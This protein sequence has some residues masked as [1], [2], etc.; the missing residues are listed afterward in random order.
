MKHVRALLPLLLALVPLGGGCTSPPDPNAVILK[1]G[2]EEV[3][4]GAFQKSFA[5][6]RLSVGGEGQITREALAQI[7]DRVLDEWTEY[8]LVH[9]EA[10]AR[11]VEVAPAEVEQA[12]LRVKS[13]YP[14]GIFE[15]TLRSEGVD[16]AAWREQIARRV[17]I[18]KFVTQA[19]GPQITIDEG[20][21]QTYYQEH[22]RDYMRPEEVRARQIA[23]RTEDEARKT[24]DDLKKGGDFAA[25][26]RE[27][28]V[29]PDGAN[30]GDLGF[31]S[32]GQ[33]I[34][35]FDVAFSLPVGKV[36]DVVK[37]PY[38]W[39]LFQVMERHKPRNLTFAEVRASI[40]ARVRDR[41]AQE[42]YSTWLYG[43][44]QSARIDL[45][46]ALVDRVV[47]GVRSRIL[48]VRSEPEGSTDTR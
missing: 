47:A 41:K 33:M 10:V 26:A 17:L 23:L 5:A 11:K 3:T 25:L 2:P 32:R 15:R 21:L 14:E 6:A 27:R 18:A 1:V 36:S 7:A 39:H 16:E 30:G 44:R 9:Q 28:S 19:I 8:C 43:V 12:V 24:L 42:A 38:G 13:D 48:P 31:F 37:S 35:E 34:P 29:S 4:V 45:N 40:L 20:E 46:R 22:I